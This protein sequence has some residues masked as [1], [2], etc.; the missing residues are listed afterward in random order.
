MFSLRTK[1]GLQ[2]GPVCITPLLRWGHPHITNPGG[3]HLPLSKKVFSHP[4]P[5]RDGT[6]T[7]N[8]HTAWSGLDP[9]HSIFQEME[10]QMEM[11][12]EGGGRPETEEC[13]V[14]G[15][16]APG[17]RQTVPPTPTWSLQ[18]HWLAAG[19]F[20]GRRIPIAQAALC[21]G[22]RQ[23]CLT[24]SVV[25]VIM[26]SCC[27]VSENSNGEH[28]MKKRFWRYCKRTKKP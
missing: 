26:V 23:A 3:I 21:G 1:L 9:A 4:P 17:L 6:R 19:G 13:V 15:G 12:L 7:H 24:S 10:M 22:S 16:P 25:M 2:R 11:L 27:S 8:S 14:H 5:P 18:T 28:S 20:L